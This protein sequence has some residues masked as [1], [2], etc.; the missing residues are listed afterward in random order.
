MS[1]VMLSRF[2]QGS[3]RFC[4]GWADCPFV[5]S[6]LTGLN[7]LEPFRIR[8]CGAFL[9]GSRK[10]RGTGS[11]PHSQ[12]RKPRGSRQ[13]GRE[14][15]TEAARQPGR[16][17]GRRAAQRAASSPWT[18][19]SMPHP[20]RNALRRQG[21]AQGRAGHGRQEAPAADRGSRH[22][23]QTRR[24]RRQVS[25]HRD[26]E[27]AAAGIRDRQPQ[28]ERPE[29]A[30]G[31]HRPEPGSASIADR[32]RQDRQRIE[33][34]ATG[35]RPG[36]REAQHRQDRRA[37]AFRMAASSRASR[38]AS[39][40]TPWTIRSTGSTRPHGPQTEDGGSLHRQSRA[41][42]PA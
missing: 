13:R 20:S 5:F 31:Q 39:G 4:Q 2:C 30:R 40:P 10:G 32:H 3:S 29:P 38:P 27:R 1:T 41:D 9:Y 16:Q 25:L 14:S 34:R 11:L 26:R 8:A 21:R 35:S 24:P 19:L 15:R 22:Q 33:D 28:R 18:A 17:K 7:T 36:R 23:R 6:H 37:A 42:E 12:Q